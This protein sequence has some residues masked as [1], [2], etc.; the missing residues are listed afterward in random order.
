[1]TL[2][3]NAAILTAVLAILLH[4]AYTVR[5]R[6]TRGVRVGDIWERH[7]GMYRVV[8]WTDA[9]NWH[10]EHVSGVGSAILYH[11]A[12]M[13]GQWWLVRRGS[14]PASEQL[15]ELQRDGQT[16][17]QLEWARERGVGPEGWL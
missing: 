14:S 8:R 12:R 6:S 3:L 11:A 2:L 9:G 1:M 15:R 4:T 7:D 17:E 10:T 16:D 13:R 5:L